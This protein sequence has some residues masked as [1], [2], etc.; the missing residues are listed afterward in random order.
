MRALLHSSKAVDKATTKHAVR[1]RRASPDP[2]LGPRVEVLGRPPC[3]Q[4]DLLGVGEGL[5]GERLAPEQPPP[6]FLQ[7]QPAGPRR[8]RNGGHA[9]MLSQPLLYGPTARAGEMV[10]AQGKLALGM[11]GAQPREEP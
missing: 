7:V 2:G 9:R 6:A 1:R 8:E 4:I 3:R 10:A 11:G 5:A